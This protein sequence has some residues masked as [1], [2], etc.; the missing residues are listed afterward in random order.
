MYF[1]TEL[2]WEYLEKN[3]TYDK[4][5]ELMD[6]I[7]EQEKE[8]EFIKYI[9]EHI[10]LAPYEDDVLDLVDEL[11]E[12]PDEL[13]FLEDEEEEKSKMKSYKVKSIYMDEY[14][15]LRATVEIDGKDY[16]IAEQME[17]TED[18]IKRGG[19]DCEYFLNGRENPNFSD[20]LPVESEEEGEAL[21][22]SIIDNMMLLYRIKEMEKKFGSV[23]FEGEKYI[24]TQDAYLYGQADN[25]A[26][27]TNAIKVGDKPNE[28]N[29]IPLYEVTWEIIYPE[30]EDEGNR[31][32]WEHPVD[33]KYDGLNMDVESGYVY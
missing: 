26:Y 20:V 32:D 18:N 7:E 31:C 15:G 24:F 19:A 11:A 27:F 23:E 21:Y 8:D 29:L 22:K 28:M 3:V 12:N 5:R 30:E 10:Y 9:E 17:E 16:D 14:A 4:A 13:D 2:D 33:V 25:A 6:R 1:K